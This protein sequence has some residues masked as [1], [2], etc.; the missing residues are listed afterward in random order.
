MV[1]SADN[2]AVDVGKRGSGFKSD[3]SWDGMLVFEIYGG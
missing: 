1:A 3:G 2:Y